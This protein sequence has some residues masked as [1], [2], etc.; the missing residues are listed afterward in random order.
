[1]PSGELFANV[2]CFVVA[3]KCSR[4]IIFRHPG[5]TDSLM[6]G[7]CIVLPERVFWIVGYKSLNHGERAI[8]QVERGVA[9]TSLLEHETHPLEC[10]I[11]DAPAFCVSWI[12]CNKC[13]GNCERATKRFFRALMVAA[14]CQNI[15]E[16]SVT[17]GNA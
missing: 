12:L 8:M 9:F 5:I 3:R 16:S 14:R 13:L 1:M 7:G 10:D 6:A 4:P 11:A 15:A 2:D 17:G